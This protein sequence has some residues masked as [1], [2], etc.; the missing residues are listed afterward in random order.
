MHREDWA[1]RAVSCGPVVAGHTQPAQIPGAKYVHPRLVG[2]PL[3]VESAWGAVPV[4]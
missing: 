2:F 3:L 1:L 4:L